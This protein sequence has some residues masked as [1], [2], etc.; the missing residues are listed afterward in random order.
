[1]IFFYMDGGEGGSMP[2]R[3]K[4]QFQNLHSTG[5]S[6]IVE[7]TK[8]VLAEIA[9]LKGKPVEEKEQVK[10]ELVALFSH[11]D[12]EISQVQSQLNIEQ[13]KMSQIINQRQLY[14]DQEWEVF[15]SIPNL[16]KEYN[17]EILPAQTNY[18][19]AKKRKKFQIKV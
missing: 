4:E 15:A 1:M 7:I 2:F 5:I 8:L 16:F 11:L 6:R 18:L 17:V 10:K 9:Y 3:W 19:L 14:T 13:R 12:D